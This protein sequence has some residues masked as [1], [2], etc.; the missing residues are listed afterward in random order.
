MSLCFTV[1]SV[2]VFINLYPI[3]NLYS[4]IILSYSSVGT[5]FPISDIFKREKLASSF[6]SKLVIKSGFKLKTSVIYVNKIEKVPRYT[7][8]EAIAPKFVKNF[9]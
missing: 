9:F 1:S 5:I 7:Q 2:V 4:L 3:K 8:T 6:D